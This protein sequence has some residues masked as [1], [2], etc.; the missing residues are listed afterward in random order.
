[1]KDSFRIAE[2]S[3]GASHW[4]SSFQF[5]IENSQFEVLRMAANFSLE[6]MK[7]IIK[8][9][10]NEVDAFAL[11]DLPP[12]V[13]I[14]GKSYVHRQYLEIMQT[15]CS[16]ALCDGAGLREIANLNSMIQ[17]LEEHTISPE[18]GVFFPAA[19]LSVE[20]EE[21]L[22]ARAKKS[23]FLGDAFPLLGLP[24]LIRP[25]P[26]LTTL[27]EIV[28][29]FS[30]LKDVRKNTPRIDNQIHKRSRSAIA[31]QLKNIQYVCCD[32][33]FLMMYEGA[34]DFVKGKDVIIWS[35]H[36]RME[37]ELKSHFPRSI[38]NLFP[39]EYKFTSTMNYSVL[40][41]AMRLKNEKRAAMT[42]D[43]WGKLLAPDIEIRQLARKYADAKQKSFQA[44]VSYAI[45]SLKSELSHEVRPDFAFIIHAL[46]HQDFSHL[47]GIGPWVKYLPPS[48]NDGFDRAVALAPP[49]VWGKIRHIQSQ[50]NGREVQG[51]IYALAS[52][53][54]V[55]Q[56]TPPELTYA[57]IEKI[58]SDA[59]ARGA[60]IIGLG[61]Y[62]KMIG[63]AGLTIHNQSPIPVTTGN[64]LSASATLWGLYDVVSRM[65]LLNR[66]PNTGQVQGIAMIIGASGSI[67][68]VSA[69]LLAMV[70]EKIVLVAPRINR[71]Q[72]LKAE[73]QILAPQCEVVITT[74][75]NHFAE[76]VDVLVTATSAFDQK[77][78]DIMRLKP[79]CVVCDCSRPLDFSIEEA[80][81]RPDVLI[82]ESGEVNLPGP[83]QIDFDLQLPGN[84]V[85]ACLGETA[86]LALE[87]RYE[88]FTLGRDIDWLKVKEIYKMARKHGVK[89]SAIQGH[90]GFVSDRE[91]ALT[92][93]LAISRRSRRF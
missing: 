18:Q 84:S 34:L 76:S 9:L 91:I 8:S 15:P 46:T 64:S 86:L 2:I 68:C 52:T 42:M 82:L 83:V 66:N 67:G 14:N 32:L 27:A 6:T 56:N 10:R 43:E 13:K 33:S 69:K 75:A 79:G 80:K 37:E 77:I 55:L 21:I 35:H 48:W 61:A 12:V 31:A 45:N 26:G 93:E 23:I 44:K 59:A 62:T 1:M 24:W 49:M 41:A 87:E 65:K 3:F 36:P 89:L 47:P 85:Y 5:N 4:D 54:K 74:D 92:R 63:D 19:F 29:N 51:I 81:K 20:I 53:P 11:T 30:N 7:A 50:A 72:A 71:L 57:K 60:K 28:L 16:V 25:F 58:C 38:I 73:L 88:A 78:V 39:P 70:F 40:D 90:M 17:A 22:R